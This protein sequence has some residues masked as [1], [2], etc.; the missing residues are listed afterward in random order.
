MKQKIQF[1]VA[2]STKKVI[3]TD[4]KLKYFSLLHTPQRTGRSDFF[5]PP[6]ADIHRSTPRKHPAG[7]SNHA[8][9]LGPGKELNFF[10]EIKIWGPHHIHPCFPALL[11]YKSHL[12][13]KKWQLFQQG[14]EKHLFQSYIAVVKLPPSHFSISQAAAT[15]LL[16]LLL[17]AACWKQENR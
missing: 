14:E 9:Q 17:K 1:H 2:L 4:R 16:A 5:P 13:S 15:G 3:Q 10:K 12:Y 7:C 11:K 8:R 6:N